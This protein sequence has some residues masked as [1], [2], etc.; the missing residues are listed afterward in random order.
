M[1]LKLAMKLNI[2]VYLFSIYVLYNN[3]LFQQ[4]VCYYVY[5]VISRFLE[6]HTS[7][8]YSETNIHSSML[9]IKSASFGSDYAENKQVWDSIYS[10][11]SKL[12]DFNLSL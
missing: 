9:Q 3:K 2:Y 8:F 10:L 4:T 6:L 7:M 11:I 1:K 5:T 12:D